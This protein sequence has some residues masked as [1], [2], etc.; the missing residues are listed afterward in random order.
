M[1]D[2]AAGRPWAPGGLM[3]GGMMQLFSLPLLEE[4]G[5][6]RRQAAIP[7]AFNRVV[8]VKNQT[9]GGTQSQFHTLRQGKFHLA[10]R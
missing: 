7:A 10:I 9:C 1:A 4:R 2:L 5:L 8:N 3:F 6:W